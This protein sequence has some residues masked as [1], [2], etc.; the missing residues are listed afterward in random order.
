MTLLMGRMTEL[1]VHVV[2]TVTDYVTIFLIF[3]EDKLNKLENRLKFEE[4]CA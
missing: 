4:C 3:S 1:H 2:Q